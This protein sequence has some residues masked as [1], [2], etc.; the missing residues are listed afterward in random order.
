MKFPPRQNDYVPLNITEKERGIPG[1]YRLLFDY[2][3]VL[4]KAMAISIPM[5]V[6]N[7][8]VYMYLYRFKSD[9]KDKKG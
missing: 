2:L 6:A 8:I 5:A 9:G 4:F 3:V 1:L 7:Y